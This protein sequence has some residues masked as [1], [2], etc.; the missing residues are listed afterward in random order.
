[1]AEITCIIGVPETLGLRSV[2]WWPST[3]RQ[4]LLLSRL[5]SQSRACHV[6]DASDAALCSMAVTALARDGVLVV[7]GGEGGG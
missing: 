3:R 1:M 5:T 7:G 6:S 2:V 4:T